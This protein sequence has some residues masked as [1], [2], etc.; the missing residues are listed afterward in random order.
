MK[1][2]LLPLLAAALAAPF[3][4]AQFD[5]IRL[6]DG[7]KIERVRIT[8]YDCQQVEYTQKRITE[9]VP[10]E[11]VFA[12]DL[13]QVR[14]QQL[15]AAA[16]KAT[17]D[18]DFATAY[19]SWLKAAEEAEENSRLATFAQ[20]AYWEAFALARKIGTDND[21]KECLDKLAKTQGGKTA[22]WPEIWRYR[23]DQAKAQAGRDRKR[24]ENLKRQVEAYQKFVT[25]MGLS[26][27]YGIEATLY[28]IDVRALLG[29]LNAT[30]LQAEL[31]ELLPRVEGRYPDLANRVNLDFAHAVLGTKRN[32][33][34]RKLFTAIAM[35]KVADRAT[36]AKALVGRGHAW[37][38]QSPRT[39]EDAKRALLDYMRVAVLYE[40]VDIEIVGEALYHAAEAYREW[41]GPSA[42]ANVRRIRSRL[43]LK[44]ADCSW[45]QRDR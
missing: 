22:F 34:A 41:N 9:T 24:L 31:S 20:F 27:R 28:M 12:V 42:Q 40:D 1:L 35:S 5:T 21:R 16:K 7:S 13:G 29:Q 36:Q 30:K 14:V 18:E 26:E 6:T 25:D 3:C 38:R 17:G 45:A 10:R 39:A 15:F 8:S 43:K 33:D 37:F 11:R 2:R 4:R 23:L 32:E 19:Q 44:Y